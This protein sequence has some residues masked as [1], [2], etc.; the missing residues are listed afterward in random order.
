VRQLKFSRSASG[1]RRDDGASG[2]RRD[3]TGDNSPGPTGP[4]MRPFLSVQPPA[5]GQNDQD[6]AAQQHDPQ[7]HCIGPPSGQSY[8]A[9]CPE[10]RTRTGLSLGAR[11]GEPRNAPIAVDARRNTPRRERFYICTLPNGIDLSKDSSQVSLA[12]MQ[13][14]EMSV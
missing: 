4:G 3:K 5:V 14:R 13:R 10:T 8:A 7:Q 9:F 1:L 12:P 6:S 2:E 11:R